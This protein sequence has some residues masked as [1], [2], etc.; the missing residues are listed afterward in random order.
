MKHMGKEQADGLIVIREQGQAISRENF[1]VASE[2]LVRRWNFPW[3]KSNLTKNF[4][5]L[6]WRYWTI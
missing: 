3:A 4:R 6:K 5:Y 1:V 2:K